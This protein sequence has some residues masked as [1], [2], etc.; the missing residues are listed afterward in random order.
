M[1]SGVGDAVLR[2]GVYYNVDTSVVHNGLHGRSACP[3]RSVAVRRYHASRSLPSVRY[4]L[5]RHLPH[6]ATGRDDGGRPLQRG[7]AFVRMHTDVL[8]APVGCVESDRHQLTLSLELFLDAHPPLGQC[9]SI[10]VG[11][12]GII[13]RTVSRSHGF[14]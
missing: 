1:R 2:M 4:Y 12:R 10:S 13:S 7:E 11:L 5:E 3:R 8:E 14:T 9:T 6:G